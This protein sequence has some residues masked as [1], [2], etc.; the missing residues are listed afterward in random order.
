MKIKGA[1]IDKLNNITHDLPGEQKVLKPPQIDSR[2]KT[3][4]KKP[5]TPEQAIII[6]EQ[7]PLIEMPDQFF[8]PAVKLRLESFLGRLLENEEG[9]QTVK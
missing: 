6:I 3:P 2:P 7:E 1:P 9:I 5:K 8:D 4:E